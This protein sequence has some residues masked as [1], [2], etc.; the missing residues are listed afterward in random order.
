MNEK[1]YDIF[2]NYKIY[3]DVLEIFGL[4]LVFLDKVKD[5]C[6]IV[7]DINVFLVFYLIGSESLNEIKKVFE[8]LKK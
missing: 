6:K 5:K 4:I 7:F 3:F 1:D 2:V 8:K